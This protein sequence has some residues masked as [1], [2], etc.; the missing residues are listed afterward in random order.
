[1]KSKLAKVRKALEAAEVRLE[2]A[3]KLL[4]EKADEKDKL[5]RD[6]REEKE[7]LDNQLEQL[8]KEGKIFQ[9]KFEESEEAVQKAQAEFK[10]AN[11][12]LIASIM[13][14]PALLEVTTHECDK[15]CKE[16]K[17]WD[18]ESYIKSPKESIL[19]TVRKHVHNKLREVNRMFRLLKR[20]KIRTQKLKDFDAKLHDDIMNYI[21]RMNKSLGK[22]LK[23]LQAEL[24]ELTEE[25]QRLQ[26]L[27]EKMSES[28][29]QYRSQQENVLS[30]MKEELA[31][32]ETEE[33]ELQALLVGVKVKVIKL[34][35]ENEEC[36]KQNRAAFK[37]IT[38]A[39]EDIEFSDKHTAKT[40]KLIA[41]VNEDITEMKING[42]AE[43]AGLRN[44][45]QEFGTDNEKLKLKA[46]VNNNFAKEIKRKTKGIKA[47]MNR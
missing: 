9:R 11:K 41:Q 20:M 32:L 46:G 8:K 43:L 34:A 42:E 31:R 14:E 10:K 2:R 36:K 16:I 29:S 24:K 23:R 3:N 39:E 47:L 35:H 18:L 40:K 6:Q 33:E 19:L 21:S 38:R 17:N 30:S 4:D 15:T 5:E 12:K 37:K 22:S 44:G 7:R 1:M 27:C 25:A 28:I 26:L 13:G 45:I